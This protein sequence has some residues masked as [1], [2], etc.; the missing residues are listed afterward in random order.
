MYMARQYGGQALVLKVDMD[1]E[2]FEES[3][4]RAAANRK[5]FNPRSLR[6]LAASVHIHRTYS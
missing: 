4:Q 5:S 2:V 1:N 3:K 6:V